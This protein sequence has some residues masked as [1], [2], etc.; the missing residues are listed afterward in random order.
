MSLN[1]VAVEL[2]TNLVGSGAKKHDRTI[3]SEM[4]NFQYLNIEINWN[5]IIEKSV[6]FIEQRYCFLRQYNIVVKLSF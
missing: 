6:T 5:A 3:D 4:W 1:D 2:A